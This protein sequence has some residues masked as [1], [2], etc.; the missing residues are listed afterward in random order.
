MAGVCGAGE[1]ARVRAR[2][3]S[4][5]R[6]AATVA[7]GFMLALM[8]VALAATYPSGAIGSLS[9]TVPP[10]ELAW[11]HSDLSTNCFVSV[12]A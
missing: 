11:L 7:R 5:G 3:S 6:G 1:R 9:D 2:I 12:H 4:V 10:P 8:L